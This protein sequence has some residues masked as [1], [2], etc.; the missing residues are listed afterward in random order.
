MIDCWLYVVMLALTVWGVWAIVI[1][2]VIRWM[3]VLIK[4]ADRF[5]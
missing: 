2:A 4:F 1:L 5:F 3:G